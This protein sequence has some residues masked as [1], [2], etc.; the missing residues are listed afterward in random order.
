MG[1]TLTEKILSDHLTEGELEPGAR[2]AQ[3]VLADAD[4]VG[5]YDGSYQQEN[6]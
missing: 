6:L 2:V 5:K 3:L 4:H 1:Q